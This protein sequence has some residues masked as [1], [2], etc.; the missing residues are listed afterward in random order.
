M[1]K[2]PSKIQAMHMKLSRS[3]GGENKKHLGT[4]F[5]EKLEF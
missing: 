5:S 1:N 4:K 3:T 2:N